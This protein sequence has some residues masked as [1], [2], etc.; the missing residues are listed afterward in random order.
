[1]SG[2]LNGL[3][4]NLLTSLFVMGTQLY[5]QM[6]VKYSCISVRGLIVL[7]LLHQIYNV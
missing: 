6:L 5:N 1:M 3:K 2:L 7:I 4:Y